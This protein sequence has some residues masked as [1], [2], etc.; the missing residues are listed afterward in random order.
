MLKTPQALHASAADT[1]L[2]RGY[3]PIADYAAIGDCH[4]SALVATDG[5]IDWCSLER[6]DAEPVFCRLLDARRGGFLSTRPIAAHRT[7]RAYIAGTNILRT[8]FAAATGRIALIDFMPVGRAPDAG[9][10]DYVNLDAPHWLIRRIVGIEGRVE[11]QTVYRPSAEYASRDVRLEA[12]AGQI[13]MGEGGPFLRCDFHLEV[14]EDCARGIVTVA[15]GEQRFIVIAPAPLEPTLDEI[16]RL[17]SITCAFWREWIGYCRYAGPHAEMVRRSALVLKLMTYAPTGAPVAALTTSLPETMGG[18]R[19]WDYRYCWVRDASLMLQA[20][21][22]L[23]YSGEVRQFYGFMREALHGPVDQLQVMYGI[24]M[25][26]DLIEQRLDH[27][28]GYAGSKPVRIGNAAYTQ[29]QTDLYGYLL[30]GALAYA[31]LGGAISLEA[32]EAFARVADFIADCWREPDMGLWEIRSEPRH[33]VHSKAMCWAVV[34]RAIRL[35]GERPQWS[36]LREQMWN[37]I[38]TRGRA[39]D[40]QFVQS[41]VPDEPRMDASLLQI[42][43]LGTP[44]DDDTLRR[45]RMAVERELRRGDFVQ[46]YLG[47]DGL[48]GSEGAFLVCSFWLVDALLLESR[49]TEARTLFDRLCT[50]ANDVGLY[51]E[52]VDAASGAFLGNFPQA[53]T[54][55]GLIASAVNLELFDRRGAA[56]LRGTYADRARRTVW[57]TFG[58]KAVLAALYQ[59]RSLRL[60]SSSKS[61]LSWQDV[62]TNRP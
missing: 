19:N 32:K 47:H 6:F 25:E 49:A 58:W 41:F 24:R 28:E 31:A 36:K 8:A 7:S 1:K 48:R 20:L 50:Y 51:S 13:L 38:V 15:A 37:D 59:S 40:G 33:F 4:G 29:R 22:S 54:H 55:L 34:D 45:T 23:G 60:M 57:A 61:K 2:E 26:R 30:E 46:R 18:E 43:M 9:T 27:L 35:V 44:A 16:E 12:S 3:R 17:Y 53:F 39:G 11:L 42:A 62:R 52:E 21:A 5:S 56:A 14:H 10:H